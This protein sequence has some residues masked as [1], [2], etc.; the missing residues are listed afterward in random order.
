[1]LKKKLFEYVVLKTNRGEIFTVIH[2][3]CNVLIIQQL[4]QLIAHVNI[5]N[6]LLFCDGPPPCFGGPGSYVGIA[7]DYGL[8]GP[9]IESQW[10]R[11]FPPG[12]LWPTQPP[13]QWVTGLCRG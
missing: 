12:A 2:I 3:P 4:V 11:D 5:N 9:G 8:D 1:M 10:G 7:T 13:V 6:Y